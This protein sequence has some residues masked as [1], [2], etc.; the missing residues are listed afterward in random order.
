MGCYGNLHQEAVARPLN[1][2]LKLELM[3]QEGGNDTF[4]SICVTYV[5]VTETK[6]TGLMKEISSAR[7]G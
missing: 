2:F 6:S 5:I 1:F 7:T 4:V 3:L